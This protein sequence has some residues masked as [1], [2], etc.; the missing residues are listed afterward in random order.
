MPNRA[1][2]AWPNRR[3]ALASCAA[4]FP[5]GLPGGNVVRNQSASR[6]AR[7]LHASAMTA[8]L[9]ACSAVFR[10]AGPEFA[11]SQVAAR[12]MAFAAC[13]TQSQRR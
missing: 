11:R 1:S 12:R 5:T 8:A 9:R 2:A 3:L 10:N 13:G 7:L 6:F 4:T